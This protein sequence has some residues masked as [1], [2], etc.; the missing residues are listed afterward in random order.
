ML[1]RICPELEKILDPVLR[2]SASPVRKRRVCCRYGV[3]HIVRPGERELCQNFRGSRIVDRKLVGR[4][5]RAPLSS[6]AVQVKA[7]CVSPAL[8]SGLGIMNSRICANSSWQAS[9]NWRSVR[10]VG[11]NVSKSSMDKPSST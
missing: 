8:K 9:M 6:D 5:A 10:A 3:I 1:S 2:G 11:G 7:H 4:A